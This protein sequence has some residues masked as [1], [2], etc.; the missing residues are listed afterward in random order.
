MKNADGRSVHLIGEDGQSVPHIMNLVNVVIAATRGTLGERVK[1]SVT[2]FRCRLHDVQDIA[3]RN[4]TPLCDAGPS[5]DAKMSRDLLKE[6]SR[7]ASTSPPT[8]SR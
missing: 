2:S 4:T 7:G 8:R 3:H 6:N 5:L 1:D